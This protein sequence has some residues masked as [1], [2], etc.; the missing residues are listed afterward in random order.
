MEFD[1]GIGIGFGFG[2]GLTLYLI[3]FVLKLPSGRVG[4]A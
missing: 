3:N 1:I 2:F 4:A